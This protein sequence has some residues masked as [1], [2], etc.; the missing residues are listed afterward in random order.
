MAGEERF[1]I[2]N[3]ESRY[4]TKDR[5]NY[6]NISKTRSKTPTFGYVSVEVFYLKLCIP[7]D[8]YTKWLCMKVAKITVT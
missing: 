8:S 4:L 2:D 6:S 5:F 1:Y 7:N 3:E